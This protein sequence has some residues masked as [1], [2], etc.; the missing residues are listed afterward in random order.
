MTWNMEDGQGDFEILGNLVP[1]QRWP[2]YCVFQAA[3]APG[4]ELLFLI[5]SPRKLPGAP[6][7]KSALYSIGYGK[8]KTLVTGLTNG[9][10]IGW[11]GDGK[12]IY[13]SDTSQKA[14]YCGSYDVDRNSIG[15]FK[16]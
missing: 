2:K 8:Q 10:G 14:T 9:E 15:M 1:N 12:K 7:Y 11:S 3:V 13:F 16:H 5:A 6:Q 4:K